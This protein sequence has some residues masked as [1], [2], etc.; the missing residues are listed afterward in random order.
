VR[1][2]RVNTPTEMIPVSATPPIRT[3]N[4]PSAHSDPAIVLVIQGGVI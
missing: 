1:I 4:P 2:A 3:G